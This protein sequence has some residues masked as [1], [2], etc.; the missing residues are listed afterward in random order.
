MKKEVVVCDVCERGIAT[1]KCP[2]CGK[3]VC[4]ECSELLK[5]YS[6]QEYG[7]TSLKVS[8]TKSLLHKFNQSTWMCKDCAKVLDKFIELDVPSEEFLIELLKFLKE[9]IRIEIL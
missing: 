8:T 9:R 6:Y 5:F 7:G 3:D 2:I 1:T 4:P